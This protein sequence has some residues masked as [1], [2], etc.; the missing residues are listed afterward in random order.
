M[1]LPSTLDSF[2]FSLIIIVTITSCYISILSLEFTKCF[3]TYSTD[4]EFAFYEKYFISF[5][6]PNESVRE[7]RA[8]I[9]FPFLQIQKQ[10]QE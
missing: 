10:A 7:C 3:P 1:I 2:S 9:I 8:G 5:D 6:W 4:K